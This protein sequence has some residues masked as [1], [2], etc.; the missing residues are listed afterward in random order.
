M[1]LTCKYTFLYEGSIGGWDGCGLMCQMTAAMTAS[2]ETDSNR[3][4]NTNQELLSAITKPFTK[5]IIQV[6]YSL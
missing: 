2:L 5:L 6:V 1:W 4:Y 3:S